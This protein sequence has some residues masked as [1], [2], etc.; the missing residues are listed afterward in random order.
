MPEASL[1]SL[2]LGSVHRDHRKRLG[3][4]GE[5]PFAGSYDH[6]QPPWLGHPLHLGRI[7]RSEKVQDEGRG[8]VSDGDEVP[9]IGHNPSCTGV[10]NR[11]LAYRLLRVI[12]P[13]TGHPGQDLECPVQIVARPAA[14]ID[15]HSFLPFQSGLQKQGSQCPGQ[16]IEQPGF[17]DPVASGQHLPGVGGMD[18]TAGSDQ[19][20]VALSGYIE[21][22]PPV[23]GERPIF[24]TQILVTDRA[25]QSAVERMV[26]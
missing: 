18:S 22:M 7:P 26:V 9:D 23:T 8:I 19:V 21:G 24:A 13:D 1:E 3:Q 2:R 25:A 17:Q 6:D 11:G 4:L 14:E 20:D 16:G 10:S 15:Y 12:Q 5:M